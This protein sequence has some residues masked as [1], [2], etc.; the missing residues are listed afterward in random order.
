MKKLLIASL[1]AGSFGLANHANAY[2]NIVFDFNGAAAGGAQTI[3]YFD[4]LPGNALSVGSLGDAQ[5]NIPTSFTTY[6]QAQLGSGVFDNGS[7]TP[8]S[9]FAGS[10]FT[11]QASINE[12][13]IGVGTAN[14]NLLVTGGTFSVY[15]DPTA[16]SN[17]ITGLGYGGGGDA[18]KILSGTIASGNGTFKDTYRDLH[19]P[20]P[21]LPF[22]ICDVA[23]GTDGCTVGLL[24]KSGVDNQNGVLTH[25]GTGSSTINIMITYQDPNFFKTHLDMI[26]FGLND[27]TNL[28]DPF[29]QT[30][31]S[32][33][34]FG[35]TP[36]YSLQTNGSKVNGGDCVRGGMSEN[37]VASRTCDF[38]FQ[39]DA[40]T[41]FAT[42]PEPG[43]VAMLG[44]GLGLM[45][46]AG[47][48]SKKASA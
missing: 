30:N 40:S 44:L 7:Q 36:Y 41:S 32:D 1:V 29:A 12:T 17:T 26:N 14:V 28:A 27:T 6:Y 34:V 16:D 24:D 18:I 20:L 11:V 31:P 5:G 22:S 48:R 39:T 43:T 46:F 15:Y 21:N 25:A 47:R 38:Q 3:S 19:T 42:V 33:Q 9:P 8:Y 45:G 37:N 10:E 2:S 23:P 4:W 13:Q 35:N